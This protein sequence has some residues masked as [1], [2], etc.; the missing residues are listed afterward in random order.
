MTLQI[1]QDATGVAVLSLYYCALRMSNFEGP[2]RASL[3]PG[4]FSEF[5]LSLLIDDC[6]Y[7]LKQ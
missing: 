2:G 6:F 1:D 3:V 5:G 7:Y 4:N